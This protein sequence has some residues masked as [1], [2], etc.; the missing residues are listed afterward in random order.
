M[1]WSGDM[2]SLLEIPGAWI[3]KELDLDLSLPT[4]LTPSSNTPTAYIRTTLDEL[5]PSRDPPL[6][7]PAPIVHSTPR[8]SRCH[9]GGG[10]DHGVREEAFPMPVC[11]IIAVEDT[12]QVGD[13]KNY[14]QVFFR[15]T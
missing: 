9:T 12:P 2:S 15:P 8:A 10:P 3:S 1:D 11:S 13:I 4:S 5:P 6:P 7:T 14:E